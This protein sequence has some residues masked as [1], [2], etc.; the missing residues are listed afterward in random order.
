MPSWLQ[1]LDGNK[2]QESGIGK[3][4]TGRLTVEGTSANGFLAR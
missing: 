3:A 4:K 2:Y 1:I